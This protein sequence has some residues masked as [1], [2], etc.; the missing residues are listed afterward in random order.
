M[1][2]DR[3]RE[4][5][6][7]RLRQSGGGRRRL[8]LCIPLLLGAGALSLLLPQ[9]FMSIMNGGA[10]ITGIQVTLHSKLPLNL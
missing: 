4:R 7:E 6:D 5:E 8:S 9:L 3:E 10:D 1:R 2:E